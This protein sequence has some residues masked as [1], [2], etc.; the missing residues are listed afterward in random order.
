MSIH[1]SRV[2]GGIGGIRD[3]SRCVKVLP[4]MEQEAM[5]VVVRPFISGTGSDTFVGKRSCVQEGLG[6]LEQETE[7]TEGYSGT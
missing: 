6:G 7:E 5:E 3:M 1:L 2:P 4:H